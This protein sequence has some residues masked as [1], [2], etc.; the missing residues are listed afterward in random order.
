MSE[1]YDGDGTADIEEI[2]VPE[3]GD[4]LDAAS[5]RVGAE[6]LMDKV[7]YILEGPT[8][9]TGVKAHNGPGGG[10]TFNV[11]VVCTNVISLLG[12]TTTIVSAGWGF[13]TPPTYSR[14]LPGFSVNTATGAIKWPVSPTINAG[15]EVVRY[16][17]ADVPNG[18]TLV[19]VGARIDPADDADPTTK[20]RI[21]L[22]RTALDGSGSSAVATIEDP[23]S[24]GSYQAAH[25]FEATFNHVL[26]LATY[27]YSIE[28]IGESGG[29]EDNVTLQAPP[30]I[31]YSVPSPDWGQ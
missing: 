25:N 1:L 10:M 11:G 26:D 2:T 17:L 27:V 7:E 16:P 24:G 28:L 9:Y 14:G 30:T 8:Q 29:D 22:Q 12:A 5:Y 31:T 3:D 19:S 18:S 15:G 23:L 20:F 21:R 13:N 6:A 4:P